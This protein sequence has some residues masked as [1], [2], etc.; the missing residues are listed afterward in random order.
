[1]FYNHKALCSAFEVT[2]CDDDTDQRHNLEKREKMAIW[3]RNT[4]DGARRDW[5]GKEMPLECKLYI[6]NSE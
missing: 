6:L 5:T 2:A 4:L 1:M 3:T